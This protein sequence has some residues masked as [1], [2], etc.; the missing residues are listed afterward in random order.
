MLLKSQTFEEFIIFSQA[1]S[2]QAI[3]MQCLVT[4]HLIN[5]DTLPLLYTQ[6]LLHILHVSLIASGILPPQ[7]GT[8]EG[9]DQLHYFDVAGFV[10]QP[11]THTIWGSLHFLPSRVI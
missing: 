5:R 8:G 4:I 11:E 9:Y 3:Q 6:V 10:P 7:K 1:I 2:G